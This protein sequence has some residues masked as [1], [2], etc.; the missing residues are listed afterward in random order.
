MTCN[1]FILN[2]VNF[3]QYFIFILKLAV[4]NKIC[5]CEDQN[6]TFLCV[7]LKRS[8]N[9]NTVDRFCWIF[10]LNGSYEF[11]EKRMSYFTKINEIYKYQFYLNQ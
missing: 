2:K 4:T 7:S 10:V 11:I 1:I 6:M 8:K 9:F 3:K 5:I